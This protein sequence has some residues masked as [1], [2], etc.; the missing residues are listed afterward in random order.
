MNKSNYKKKVFCQIFLSNDRISLWNIS[1]RGGTGK[2]RSCWENNIDVV[3]S[4][5]PELPISKNKENMVIN[6]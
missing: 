6:R 5:D 4:F 3:V 2:L 1:E